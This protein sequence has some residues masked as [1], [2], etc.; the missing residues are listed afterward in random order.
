MNEEPKM[1]WAIG[2]DT[3]FQHAIQLQ[4]FRGW[5]RGFLQSPTAPLSGHN[6]QAELHMPQPWAVQPPQMEMHAQMQ[7]FAP[8]QE[9]LNRVVLVSSLLDFLYQIVSPLTCQS[10]EP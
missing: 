8:G 7:D 2:S 1:K 10:P 9:N 5:M 6:E 4:Q 3:G